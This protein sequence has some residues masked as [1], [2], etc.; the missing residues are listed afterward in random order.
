MDQHLALFDH[1]K[2]FETEPVAA[3]PGHAGGDDRLPACEHHLVADGKGLLTFDEGALARQV[4]QPCVHL[5]GAGPQPD[6]EQHPRP[7]HAALA[8]VIDAAEC[9]YA[10]FVLIAPNFTVIR[11]GYRGRPK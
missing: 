11:Q 8:G 2:E 7:L 3:G 5:A 1:A 10:H 6:G 4:P 9:L